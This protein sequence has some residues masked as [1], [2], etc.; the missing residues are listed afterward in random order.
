MRGRATNERS[1]TIPAKS[2]GTLGVVVDIAIDQGGCVETSRPTS[3]DHPVFVEEGVI[4]YCVANMPG[5]VPYTSTL[6]LTNATLPYAVQLANKGWEKAC[7]ENEELKKG[8]NI[9]N[10]KILYKGVAEA[11]NLPYN[12]ELVPTNA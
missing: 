7:N 6:A 11:W 4:H 3:H 5:A 12:E 9:A 1:V 10:G 8:L 2:T